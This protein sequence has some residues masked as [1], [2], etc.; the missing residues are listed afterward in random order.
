MEAMGTDLVVLEGMGRS[1]HTNLYA[2]FKCEALKLAIVK[3]EWLARSLG[4]H[5]FSVVCKY[6]AV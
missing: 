3:N 6:E 5:L 2:R 4:G 1:I